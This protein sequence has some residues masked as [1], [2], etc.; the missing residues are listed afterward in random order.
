V[1]LSE[2]TVAEEDVYFKLPVVVRGAH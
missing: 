1:T 2:L